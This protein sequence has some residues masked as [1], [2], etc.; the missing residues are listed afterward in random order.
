MKQPIKNYLQEAIAIV[1]EGKITASEQ[2][3][4]IE[5]EDPTQ[6]Y[7]R[8]CRALLQG[9]WRDNNGAELARENTNQFNSQ[10]EIDGGV[11]AFYQLFGHPFLAQLEA[12]SRLTPNQ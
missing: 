3:G 8:L 9:K 4:F 10:V 6:D 5:I 1:T 7:V 12:L 11:L 2:T